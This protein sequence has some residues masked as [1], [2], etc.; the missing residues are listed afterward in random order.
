MTRLTGSK[1]MDMKVDIAVIVTD[2][3]R[4]ALNIEHH[5]FEYDPPGELV[6]TSS[7]IPM[8][9]LIP[10]ALTTANPKNGKIT[11]CKKIP[12]KRAFLF[13]SCLRR[14]SHSTVA[15]IPKTRANRRMLEP[16]SVSAPI[17]GY[18]LAYLFKFRSCAFN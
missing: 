5:Q 11:N 16:A 8:G 7:V 10:S 2:N 9:L 3:A 4:S 17:F 12:V 6:T 13:R 14:F 1:N 15:D 18:L